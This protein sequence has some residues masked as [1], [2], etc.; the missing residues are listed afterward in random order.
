MQTII[1]QGEGADATDPNS[2]LYKFEHMKIPNDVFPLPTDPRTKSYT[3][4]N[5][6]AVC[7]H[8]QS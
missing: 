4:P 3:D 8:V 2:H 6:A 1:D 7:I 5:V